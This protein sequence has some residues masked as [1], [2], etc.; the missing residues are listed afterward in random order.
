MPSSRNATSLIHAAYLRGE[1]A[2]LENQAEAVAREY[3]IMVAKSSLAKSS[4]EAAKAAAKLGFPVVTKVVSK[5]ILH[6]SD[7]GGVKTGVSSQTQVRE[8]FK[9][10]MTNAKRSNANAVIEGILVQKMAPKGFEFVVG[11]TRD[12]QFGPTVMFGLGGI[13]VELFKDV[14]FRLSPLSQ[15]E[16]LSMMKE[17][18]SSALLSGFRGSKPL[19]VNSAAKTIVAVGRLLQEQSEIES[20]DINP[21]FIYP[22]GV[23]AVDVRMIL[24]S[25]EAKK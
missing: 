10:I 3:G 22:K 12:P 24:K 21:L 4:S 18:K 11:G 15:E 8:A 17:I 7:I 16:A 6:K 13:Y 25:T 2:L 23:V 1:H 5:D 19:D 9:E 20:I 14:S